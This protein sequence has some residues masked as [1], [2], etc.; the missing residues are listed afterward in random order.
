M[1]NDSV[2]SS[3]EFKLVGFD[4]FIRSNP[5]TDLF[6][7]SE[8]IGIEFYCSDASNIAN[9]FSYSLGIPLIAKSDQSTGNYLYSSYILESN[10]IQLIFTSPNNLDLKLNNKTLNYDHIPY[11][12]YSEDEANTFIKKHGLAVRTI[13]LAVSDAYEA[14]NISI[15]NGAISYMYPIDVV[16]KDGS[17]QTIGEIILYGDVIL[18]FVSDINNKIISSDAKHIINTKLIPKYENVCSTIRSYGFTN[19]DHVVGN[20]HNLE[21]QINYMRQFSGWHEFTE[22]CADDIGTS[23]SGLNSMV[24]ANNAETLL[25]AINEPTHST[26]IKSQIQTFLEQNNGPGVQHIALK[27][28]NIFS[29]MNI[30]KSLEKC[31]GFQFMEPPNSQYYANLPNRIG[32]IFTDL[33]YQL[34]SQYGLLVDKDD[35]GVILQIFTKPLGDRNTIFIEIIQR[36]CYKLDTDN[37]MIPIND[38]HNKPA[39]GGFGK[40]NF[41]ELFKSIENY[42]KTLNK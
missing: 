28:D 41:S 13:L 3:S 17:V 31:G 7:S 19:I 30:L 2:L 34:I 5:Q 18:R 10:N 40:G 12:S 29:T 27:T 16:R 11:I 23:E 37:K 39:C 38:D 8:I 21:K 36:Y 32:N 24:L 33:E 25:L 9:R 15:M 1:H 42:G 14:Y 20:V 6:K 22:F 35:Q 26:L 4:N